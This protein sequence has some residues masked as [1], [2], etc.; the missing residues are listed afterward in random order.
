MLVPD[1][2]ATYA[3]ANCANGKCSKHFHIL[4]GRNPAKRQNNNKCIL[5][6][7]SFHV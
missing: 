3:A 5:N 6:L 2:A 1:A 7:N 4:G